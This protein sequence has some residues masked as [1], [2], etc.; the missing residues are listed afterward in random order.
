MKGLA[1]LRSTLTDDYYDPIATGLVGKSDVLRAVTVVD[2]R[3]HAERIQGDPAPP[4]PHI[5][6]SLAWMNRGGKRVIVFHQETPA[7]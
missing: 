3:F 5:R 4:P 6:A 1:L 2:S 7:K